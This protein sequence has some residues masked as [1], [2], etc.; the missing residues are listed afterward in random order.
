[1]PRIR[2]RELP[3][4]VLRHLLLRARERQISFEQLGEFSDWLSAEPIVPEGKWYKRFS[5]FTLCG[6]GELAK[7]FLLPGQLPEGIEVQ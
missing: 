4:A 3:E 6:E 5:D 7:T 2:R 1:M